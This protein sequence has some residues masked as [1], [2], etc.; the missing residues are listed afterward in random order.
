MQRWT[1]PLSV[2]SPTLGTFP[3]IS[4]PSEPCPPTHPSSPLPRLLPLPPRHP[5]SARRSV[6]RTLPL[7]V[8]RLRPSSRRNPHPQRPRTLRELPP[9]RRR[10]LSLLSL[11]QHPRVSR[12][13]L[14][15]L[16]VPRN[17]PTRLALLRSPRATRPHPH[18]LNLSHRCRASR[19]IPVLLPRAGPRRPALQPLTIHPTRFAI[20][21]DRSG[22]RSGG[23]STMYYPATLPPFNHYPSRQSFRPLLFPPLTPPKSS[24]YA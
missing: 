14:S 6:S 5:R 9:P 23:T 18:Q 20:F 3:R 2:C 15:S 22:N 7:L 21:N 4:T 8:R 16:G 1:Y 11:L 12:R 17:L 10:I 19:R 13:R 24:S